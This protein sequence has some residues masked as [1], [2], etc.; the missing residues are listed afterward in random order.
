LLITKHGYMADN[1]R[2]MHIERLT[3]GETI[4]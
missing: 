1:I 3:D 4:Q 2:I